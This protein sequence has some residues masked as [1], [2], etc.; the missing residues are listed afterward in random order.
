L[1]SLSPL[2]ANDSSAGSLTIAAV[3]VTAVAVILTI[4]FGKLLGEPE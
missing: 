2:M 3:I 1:L 4:V